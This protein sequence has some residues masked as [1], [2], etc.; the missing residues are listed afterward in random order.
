MSYFKRGWE[1]NCVRKTLLTDW[2]DMELP[3]FTVFVV[4]LASLL[5]CSE[6]IGEILSQVVTRRLSQRL[7]AL[8]KLH[9]TTYREIQT[10]FDFWWSGEPQKAVRRALVKQVPLTPTP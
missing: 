1:A 10:E 8:E 3:H 6:K 9:E 5:Y 4:T 2:K 7:A